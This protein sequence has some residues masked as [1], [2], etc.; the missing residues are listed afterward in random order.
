M[1]VLAARVRIILRHNINTTLLCRAVAY[2]M[3]ND[4]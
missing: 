4:V 3:D 2:L 1:R